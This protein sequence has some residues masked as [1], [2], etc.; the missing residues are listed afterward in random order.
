MTVI[1]CCME[2][3]A[4]QQNMTEPVSQHYVVKD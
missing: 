2:E 3:D 4:L 1:Q